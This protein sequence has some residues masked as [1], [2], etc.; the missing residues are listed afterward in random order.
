MQNAK[1]RVVVIE[2][3]ETLEK[4]SYQKHLWVA[5]GNMGISRRV[6]PNVIADAIY[7]FDGDIMVDNGMRWPI[8]LVD[9]VLGDPRWFSYYLE[10]DDEGEPRREVR[11]IERLRLI[12]LFFKIKYPMIARH[13]DK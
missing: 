9:D 3:K 5:A 12:D 2:A 8:P 11:L 4:L 10:S 7:N 6:W 13:F 1:K